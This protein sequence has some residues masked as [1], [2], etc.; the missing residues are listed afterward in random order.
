VDLHL[1]HC[2]DNLFDGRAHLVVPVS[3]YDG[4]DVTYRG[5]PTWKGR[6]MGDSFRAGDVRVEWLEP[7]RQTGVHRLNDLVLVPKKKETFDDDELFDQD[8][9]A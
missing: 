3:L 2:R 9:L 4:W 8:G 7:R 6:I 1:D 5:K